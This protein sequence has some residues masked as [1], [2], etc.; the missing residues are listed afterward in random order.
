MDLST[1]TTMHVEE[2]DAFLNQS[3]STIERVLQ[4]GYV[5]TREWKDG[6]FHYR[7]HDGMGHERVTFFATLYPNDRCFICVCSDDLKT[8]RCEEVPCE[9]YR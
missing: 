1:I 8:C 9:G 5:L 3:K 6:K 4:P 2:D 7:G